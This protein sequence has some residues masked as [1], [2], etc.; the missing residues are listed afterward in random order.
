MSNTNNRSILIFAGVVS[1]HSP[2][3]GILQ[4][5]QL[6]GFSCTVACNRWMGDPNHAIKLIESGKGFSMNSRW[7]KLGIILLE[8][9]Y[10]A[11][12]H[13][14]RIRLHFTQNTYAPDIV[15]SYVHMGD[16][17]PIQL[18]YWYAKK[19]EKPY[20]IHTVDP[21]PSVE[22][23]GEKPIFRRAVR[24]SLQRYFDY[25]SLFSANN[26][27]MLQYQVERMAFTGKQFC[28][29]TPFI[30]NSTDEEPQSQKSK[31]KMIMLYAGS[32]YGKRRPEP[33]IEGF[34]Q[35]A[36]DNDNTELWIAGRNTID[37]KT[38]SNNKAV[39]SIKLLGFVNN[40]EE[41][42]EQADVLVDI[43]ANISNDVFVSGKLVEYLHMHKVILS[44][45]PKGSPSEQW[46]SDVP[47]S[48]VVVPY[49]EMSISSGVDNAVTMATRLDKIEMQ[50]DRAFF[51]K[52]FTPDAVAEELTKK[53]LAIAIL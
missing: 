19:H 32:F 30:I 6:A 27:A 1:K 18:G 41:I 51:L 15:L 46:L 49:D 39:N 21:L 4:A 50:R 43:D 37:L 34:L 28:L 36:S 5:L 14:R 42:Y 47:H 29:Y 44:I 24:R 52:R 17:S 9:D 40:I 20:W 38:Y 31:A 48:T 13:E 16:F 23:W 25:A 11:A 26:E 35:Y 2:L 7:A 53:F 45:T 33:L 12:S 22:G 10:I 3:H 8:S